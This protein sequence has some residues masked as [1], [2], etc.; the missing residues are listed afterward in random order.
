MREGAVTLHVLY[1]SAFS[2]NSRHP[3]GFIQHALHLT[4]MYV[5][6]RQ[7]ALLRDVP[8]DLSQGP[9][10]GPCV[11]GHGRRNSPF[12]CRSGPFLPRAFCPCSVHLV[13]AFVFPC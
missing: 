13:P 4:R 2:S 12:L 7:V 8:D 6:A 9:E 10:P 3:T 1:L 11:S 5:L